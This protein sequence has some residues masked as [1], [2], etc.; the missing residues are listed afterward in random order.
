MKAIYLH[1]FLSLLQEVKRFSVDM[2]F[3][4]K[5]GPAG[6]GKDNTRDR[7]PGVLAWVPP[8]LQRGMLAIA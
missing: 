4:P 7:A 2:H 8:K 3:G 5:T 1:L 6:L